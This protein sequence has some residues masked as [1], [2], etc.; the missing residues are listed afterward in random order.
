[1][2]DANVIT[3]PVESLR[4]TATRI[5]RAAGADPEPTEILVGHLIGANLAGHDSHGVQHIPGYVRAMKKGDIQPNAQPEVTR[6]TPVSALVDGKWTF[7]QVS[8]WRGTQVAIRKA[9]ET[10]VAVVGVLRCNHI[11]RLGTYASLASEQGVVL[12]VTIGSL[13]AAT[14]PFGGRKPAFGT[15][16]FAF[17]FPAAERPDVMI[18]FATSSIALGKVAVARARH[19]P[20]PPGCALDRDGHPTTD[21]VAVFDG[22]MLLP[23]GGHKGSA[24]ATLSALL[25]QALVPGDETGEGRPQ[26]GTFILGIDAGIFRDRAQVEAE[27]DRVHDRIAAVPPAAGFAEVLVAGEPEVRSAESRRREGIPLPEDTWAEIVS[28]ARDLGLSL[29]EG[30]FS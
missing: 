10:G 23:A 29:P 20:L 25:S 15:N 27:A 1:M 4:E 5:F 3:F 14:A 26:T 18:D 8:A 28:T 9:R 16:P 24:L 30:K 21:P 17:G 12:A 7:G 2:E 11:G 13:L 6:E 22:G 19:Q